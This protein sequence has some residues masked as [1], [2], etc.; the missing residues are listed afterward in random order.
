VTDISRAQL[1]RK[2]GDFDSRISALDGFERI[3]G[4]LDFLSEHCGNL[5]RDAVNTLAVGAVRRHGYIENVI[6]EPEHGFDVLAVF[7]VGGE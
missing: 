1:G 4:F 5:S 3:V 2:V 6:V 7:T